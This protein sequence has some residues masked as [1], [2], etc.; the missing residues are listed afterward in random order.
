MVSDQPLHPLVRNNKIFAFLYMAFQV[1][2]IVLYAIFVRPQAYGAILDNGL[3][4]AVGV[5]LFVLVG[6]SSFT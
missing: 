1:A 6:T 5:A 3:F 4:E 2:F